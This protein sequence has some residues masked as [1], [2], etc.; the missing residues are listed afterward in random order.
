MFDGSYLD[1]GEH[2]SKMQTIENNYS[3]VKTSGE[4]NC[5]ALL[6]AQ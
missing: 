6:D 3:T 1:N 2:I 4:K 5:T